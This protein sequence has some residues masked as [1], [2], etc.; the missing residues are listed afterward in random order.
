MC[1]LRQTVGRCLQKPPEF[2]VKQTPLDKLVVF[3]AHFQPVS[4]RVF[5]VCD[6]I[7]GIVVSPRAGTSPLMAPAQ[8]MSS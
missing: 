2:I 4:K 1:L 8:L 6:L 5:F 3:V 7:Q